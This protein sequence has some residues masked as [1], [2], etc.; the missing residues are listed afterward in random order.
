[1]NIVHR[2]YIPMMKMTKRAA[3]LFSFQPIEIE[4]DVDSIYLNLRRNFFYKFFPGKRQRKA[5]ARGFAS[6][7]RI[8]HLAGNEIDSRVSTDD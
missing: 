1:M 2:A 8:I 3:I 7:K 6:F 5:S 4:F